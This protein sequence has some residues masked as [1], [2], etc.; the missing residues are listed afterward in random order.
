MK[1]KK[2]IENMKCGKRPKI[3][4]VPYPAQ[5]HVTPMLKLA[6][7]FHSHGFEIIM[8]TP[9]H[10]HRQIVSRVEPK[11]QIMCLPI[12]DGLDRDTPRDFFA[13]EM[14][15]E[16]NMPAVLEAMVDKLDED[17]GVV[18]MVVDLLASWAIQVA[19]RCRVPAAGFWP[20]ML[21]TY[22]LIAAIPD[23]VRTGLIYDTG[24]LC[25]SF[26]T[27]LYNCEIT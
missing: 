9:E 21:A 8:I 26:V 24:K 22:R 10:I 2:N 14:A 17:D 4:M 6:S 3:I 27:L 16:N 20:A 5:G 19:N 18:C 13:I 25:T 15:M 1:A 12:P 23:M 11:D 7:A